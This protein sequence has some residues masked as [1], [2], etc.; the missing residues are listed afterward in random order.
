MTETKKREKTSRD[1]MMN[2]SRQT[3]SHCTGDYLMLL[4]QTS[5]EYQVWAIALAPD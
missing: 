4:Q 3:S 5:E 2:L 1:R